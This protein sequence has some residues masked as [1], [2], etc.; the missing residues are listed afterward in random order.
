M[1]YLFSIKALTS[2]Q[3]ANSRLICSYPY[4]LPLFFVAPRNFLPC[5]AP[6]RSGLFGYAV[7]CRRRSDTDPHRIASCYTHWR[8]LDSYA[9][10]PSSAHDQE[11]PAFY[12]LGR[13]SGLPCASFD[14]LPLPPAWLFSSGTC[15][16]RVLQPPDSCSR[17]R[18]SVPPPEPV[19]ILSQYSS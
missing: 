15:I 13:H 19:D 7:N 6:R 16:G 12:S 10:G 5:D 4:S 8:W 9:Y 14:I 11:P 17:G 18:H 2:R 1:C 3:T